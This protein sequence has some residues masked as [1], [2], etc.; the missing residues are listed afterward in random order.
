M[1]LPKGKGSCRQESGQSCP[2][3]YIISLEESDIKS[4]LNR[5]EAQPFNGKPSLLNA[6]DARKV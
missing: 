1:L 5:L 3:I 2:G 6:H 4:P